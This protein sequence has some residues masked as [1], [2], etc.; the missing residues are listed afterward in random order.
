MKSA[1]GKSVAPPNTAAT[2]FCA[3]PSHASGGEGA[4]RDGD[5]GRLGLGQPRSARPGHLAGQAVPEAAALR[6]A[7]SLAA[8]VFGGATLFPSADFMGCALVAAVFGGATL[9]PSAD[10]MGCG[11]VA[12]G[13]PRFIAC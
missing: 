8:A 1:L 5:G 3:G 10:L 7:G 11:L 2:S 9:F 4:V 6:A 12:G 13:A